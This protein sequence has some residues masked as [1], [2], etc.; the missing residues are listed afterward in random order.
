[1]HTHHYTAGRSHRVTELLDEGSHRVEAWGNS[2]DG[3]VPYLT[4]GDLDFTYG[5]E[6]GE[7]YRTLSG[8]RADV[9]RHYGSG[10]K[11]PVGRGW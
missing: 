11:V 5:L 3:F 10:R 8:L 4:S 1:M 9:A 2:R 6:I 7:R